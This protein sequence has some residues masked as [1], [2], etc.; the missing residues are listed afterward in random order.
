MTYC[1]VTFKLTF[2][3]FALLV[4]LQSLQAPIWKSSHLKTYQSR[5]KIVSQFERCGKQSVQKDKTG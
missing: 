5:W 1:Q 3:N 4:D 2:R